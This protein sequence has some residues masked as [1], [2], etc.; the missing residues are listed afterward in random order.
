MGDMGLEHYASM[1]LAAQV[2]PIKI[3]RT[4]NAKTRRL[5]DTA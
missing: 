2:L 3:R 5:V 4:Q 1:D